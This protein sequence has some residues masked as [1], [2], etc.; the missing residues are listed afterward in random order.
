[1]LWEFMKEEEH[2]LT[3]GEEQISKQMVLEQCYSKCV[4][5]LPSLSLVMKR[6][7]AELNR[8]P[9]DKSDFRSGAASCLVAD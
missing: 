3:E 6:I 2:F 4:L 5:C 8:V 9:S 7:P 1:M